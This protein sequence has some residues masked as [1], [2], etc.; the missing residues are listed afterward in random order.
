[1]APEVPQLLPLVCPEFVKNL[2]QCS[3]QNQGVKTSGSQ[4]EQGLV[5]GTY[6][7]GGAVQ[8][9]V[10]EGENASDQSGVGRHNV[11]YSAIVFILMAGLKRPK[12]NL[13]ET[14]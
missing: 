14:R 7:R 4:P 13:R 8:C 2:A 6:L 10:G 12:G 3:S 11:T 9:R 1:M 5:N